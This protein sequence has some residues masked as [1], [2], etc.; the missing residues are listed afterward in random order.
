[1]DIRLP[2]SR[3]GMTLHLDEKLDFEVLESFIESMPRESDSEDEI[4]R[5]AMT[6]QIGRA[7]CRERV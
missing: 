6:R 4:V 2:F 5:K 3:E 7:S 1:M